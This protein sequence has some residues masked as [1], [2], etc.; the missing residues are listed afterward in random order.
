[1]LC[2][3]LG[4]ELASAAL[5]LWNKLV[6]KTASELGIGGLLPE[7]AEPDAGYYLLLCVLLGLVCWSRVWFGVA[8]WAVLQL[9]LAGASLVASVD[10][11]LWTAGWWGAAAGYSNVGTLL[12]TVVV[13]NVLRPNGW[14]SAPGHSAWRQRLPTFA[15]DEPPAKPPVAKK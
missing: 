8:Q 14:W 6:P 9:M 10:W 13:A 12:F 5:S 7:A 4:M 3:P 2:T 11:G 1:M 15:R